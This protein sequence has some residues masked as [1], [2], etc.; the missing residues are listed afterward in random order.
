MFRDSYPFVD[1]FKVSSISFVLV[2]WL[3]DCIILSVINKGKLQSISVFIEVAVI[4][5]FLSVI[6]S[7]FN[8]FINY[9]YY[10]NN[11]F[12]KVSFLFLKRSVQYSEVLDMKRK[13]ILGV[14]SLIIYTATKNICIPYS[15][16]GEELIQKQEIST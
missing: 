11:S 8:R 14:K 15:K 5:I 16:K 9:V 4:F 10:S 12:T 2:V 1:L 6:F 3:A 13:K 7:F